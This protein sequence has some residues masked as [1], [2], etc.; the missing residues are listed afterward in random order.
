MK[1]PILSGWFD[2]R[3]ESGIQEAVRKNYPAGWF[4]IAGFGQ[5]VGLSGTMAPQDGNSLL[6][7][8]LANDPMRNSIVMAGMRMLIGNVETIRWGVVRRGAPPDAE[9]DFDHPAARVLDI[10][11]MGLSRRELIWQMVESLLLTGNALLI[12][13]SDGVQIADWR[14]LRLPQVGQ[15]WYEV[16]HPFTYSWRRYS[17][18]EVAHMRHHR[19]VDGVN[20]IGIFPPELLLELRTDAE[21]A[22]FTL[23]TLSRMASINMLLMPDDDEDEYTREDAD[24]D[25]KQLGEG[26]SGPGRGGIAAMSKK[27]KVHEPSAHAG[28]R[29]DLSAIRNVNEERALA[30]MGIPPALLGIGT[31]AQNARIGA[32]MLAYRRQ[33]AHGTLQPLGLL[34]GEQLTTHLLPFYAPIERFEI[35][36]DFT[37][38]IPVQEATFQVLLEQ[39]A[40]AQS[41]GIDLHELIRSREL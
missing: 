12:P 36:A 26:Y 19:L 25:K 22:S 34:I 14:N 6:A 17:G 38:C 30:V 4:G 32:T 15:M 7:R 5:S 8:M 20:G 3:V 11:G 35:R 37:S 18:D 27:W 10:P 39:Q 21:A 23:T 33:Y 41:A 29:I 13:Q 28:N 40:L 16:R 1:I 24:E 31:G 9:L 2:R